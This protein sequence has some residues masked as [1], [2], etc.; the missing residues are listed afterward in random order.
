MSGG[1]YRIKRPT[2]V[3]VLARGKDYDVKDLGSSMAG[4][5]DLLKKELGVSLDAGAGQ[6]RWT[7]LHELSHVKH[8]QWTPERIVKRM[9]KVGKALTVGSVLAAEDARINELLT[10]A[11]PDAHKGFELTMTPEQTRRT[12]DGY[13]ASHASPTAVRDVIRAACDPAQVAAVDAELARLK[14]LPAAKLTVVGT[15]VRLAELIERLKKGG[16][17]GRGGQRPQKGAGGQEAGAGEPE[18]GDEEPEKG[19][20]EPGDEPGAGKGS[21]PEP[22]TEPGEDDDRKALGKPDAHT[23]GGQPCGG[24]TGEPGDGQTGQM[25]GAGSGT[26][27]TIPEVVEPEL[28]VP[29]R[30]G[31]FQVTTAE[32]GNAIRWSQ[33]HRI[34]TDGVVFR[35]ARRRPGALQ[36]GTVLIDGSSS[37]ALSDELIQAMVEMLPHAT[38]AMYSGRPGQG[39]TR[40][41]AARPAAAWIVVVGRN[42]KRV[43]SIGDRDRVP[44]SG[45]NCCDGPALLWL[46]RQ[47]SPRLWICDGAVTGM[48]AHTHD[49]LSAECAAIMTAGGIVQICGRTKDNFEDGL[50][51]TRV[52]MRHAVEA[53][54]VAAELPGVLKDVERGRI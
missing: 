45:D 15:T 14:T 34:V 42:G 31:N 52:M 39:Q 30:G 10:R 16:Q 48:L 43:A 44:R 28:T 20:S 9:A 32:T 53:D 17:G 47:Q 6:T 19:G 12:I 50:R 24:Q 3:G 46:S 54:C 37:M 7:Q 35:R 2:S 23:H 25:P 49:Q 1:T 29:M 40:L 21:E 27:W 8:S 22:G 5:T 38:I 13:V 51:A 11:V 4:Y 36:K 26:T 18:P 41:N 33:V